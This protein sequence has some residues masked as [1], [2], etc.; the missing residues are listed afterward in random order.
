M[1]EFDRWGNLTSAGERKFWSEVNKALIKLDQDKITLKP[2]RFHSSNKGSTDKADSRVKEKTPT[3]LLP[4]PPTQQKS[5]SPRTPVKT[6][7]SQQYICRLANE[8]SRHAR[9][10]SSHDR[11]DKYSHRHSPRHRFREERHRHHHHSH[12][13]F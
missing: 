11:D 8:Y 10:R 4:R 13:H 12:Q 2:R 5:R 6:G 1:Q 7:P 3:S 9:R